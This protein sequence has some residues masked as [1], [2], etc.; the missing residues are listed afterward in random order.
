MHPQ[1]RIMDRKL[2]SKYEQNMQDRR[3]FRNQVSTHYFLQQQ[4]C[5]DKGFDEI[6]ESGIEGT[7][8]EEFCRRV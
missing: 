5:D 4:V 7:C 2:L 1:A 3:Q 8:E 6:D